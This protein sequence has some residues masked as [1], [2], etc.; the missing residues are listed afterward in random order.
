MTP[1]VREAEPG[2]LGAITGLLDQL[3]YP[4]DEEAVA[5][6]LERVMADTASWVCVALDGERVV[7][8]AAVHVMPI[9]ER[10]DPIAR[11]TAMAVEAS[12][13]RG[14]VGTALLDALEERARAE[15]CDKIDLTTRRE[16]EEAAAFYR[17]RGFVDTSLRFV[18]DL[19]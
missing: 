9:L 18:K 10:D 13:R 5:G 8:V 7:G 14:G 4:S 2:D 16:R 12:A 6:R 1:R 3:G 15:G 17:S 19:D 11:V